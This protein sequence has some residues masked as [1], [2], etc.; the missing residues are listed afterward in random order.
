M[1]E[2]FCLHPLLLKEM[3]NH[4]S[5]TEPHSLARHPSCNAANTTVTLEVF[6]NQVV[7]P[8]LASITHILRVATEVE[9]EC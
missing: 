5:G 8:T 1:V 4:D 2:D 3:A 9:A 7:P 6:D